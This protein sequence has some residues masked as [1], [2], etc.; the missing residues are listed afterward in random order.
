MKTKGLTR[1]QAEKRYGEFLVDPDGFALA[2]A[3]AERKEKGYKNWE[4]QAIAKSDDPEATRARI[5]AFKNK[6]RTRGIIIMIL[7]SAAAVANSVMNP[8]VPPVN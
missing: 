8:Y 3:E 1:E 7:F 4:E 2:A 5:E 6:N